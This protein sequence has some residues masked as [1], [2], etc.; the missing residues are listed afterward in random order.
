MNASS[1]VFAPVCALSSVGDPAARIFP[2]VHG[3]Q[4]VE[5]LG[6]LHVGGRHH[7]AHAGAARAHALDQL[8]ELPARQRIDA[9]RRLVED[10][11]DRDRG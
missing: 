4:R 2:G 3:N 11:A 9:G 1:T 5:P 7:D 6:L 10:Q 8:P